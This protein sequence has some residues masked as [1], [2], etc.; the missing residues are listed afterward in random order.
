M[1]ENIYIFFLLLLKCE[2]FFKESL[3]IC[4]F[5]MVYFVW[6]KHTRKETADKLQWMNLQKK[7]WMKKTMFKNDMDFKKNSKI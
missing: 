2:H 5:S 7:I 3:G 6:E 4:Y 1:D